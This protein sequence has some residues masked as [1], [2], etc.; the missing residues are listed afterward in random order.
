MDFINILLIKID[1]TRLLKLCPFKFE[2]V[3]STGEYSTKKVTEYHF[4]KITIYESGI[5]CFKGSIHKLYNSLKDIKA[6]NYKPLTI[7]QIEKGI[8]D[9]YKGFN[10][11][12]FTLE[13]IIE[14]RKHLEQ[15]FNCSS[16]QMLFRN[17]E[18]GVNT[19]PLFNPNLYLKG[20]LYH[21][22]K[23][24]ECRFNG[25]FSQAIHQRYKLKIY[26]KSIQYGMSEFTL[27]IELK[28]N[29]T[30]ELKK[31]GIKTFADVNSNTLNKAKELLLRR[32]DEVMHYDYTINKKALT[33]REKQLLKSY[34]SPR[35][36]IID[37]KSNHRDRH[38]KNLQKI[39]QKHSKNLHQQLRDDISKKCVIINRLSESAKCVINTSSSIELNI[40]LNTLLNN[41]KK[42]EITGLAL[43]HEKQDAKYIRTSTLNYLHKYDKNTF[44]EVCSL[45]LSKTNG[46]RP[47]FEDDIIK[48]L[49]K[50]IRNRYYNQSQIKQFGY[51]QK[52]YQNQLELL[53]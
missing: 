6:P 51:N 14:V 21:L 47:K 9:P 48:H 4:C 11:N 22:N 39:I 5:V 12:Q 2:V 30:K 52:K 7:E 13:N 33:N 17:I 27:R 50:Q 19:T 23:P 36:W 53:I 10:G 37:L 49:A 3:E 44:S 16:H 35:Y 29:K 42:C 18:F 34:S 31:V 41:N 24:F 43:T 32:F 8:K 1:I 45:L 26:N 15:L 20:L 28:I 25:S 46:H 38:K 40:T